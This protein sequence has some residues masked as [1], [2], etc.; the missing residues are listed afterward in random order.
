MSVTEIKWPT[1]ALPESVIT[2]CFTL[3]VSFKEIQKPYL[4]HSE[5]IIMAAQEKNDVEFYFY[6]KDPTQPEIQA[7]LSRDKGKPEEKIHLITE[8]ATKLRD[9]LETTGIKKWEISVKG[10]LEA[11][12]GFLPGGK[13]GFEATLTLS[14]QQ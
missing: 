12:T 4:D 3:K 2:N 14:N 13:G 6:P 8:V 7:L 9:A 11:S 1:R 5:N 10:Y